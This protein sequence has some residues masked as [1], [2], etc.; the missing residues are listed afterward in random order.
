MA[1]RAPCGHGVVTRSSASARV[2]P[3]CCLGVRATC[4]ARIPSRA[5]SFSHAGWTSATMRADG[6][7]RRR[8]LE[9]CVAICG[10]PRWSLAGLSTSAHS[11]SRGECAQALSRGA[12]RA[13][14]AAAAR[15]AACRAR[16]SRLWA[17]RFALRST[18]GIAAA[19]RL[20]AAACEAATWC[21]CTC[22]CAWRLTPARQ[23]ESC[24]VACVA[25]SSSRAT[26]TDA[27]PGHVVAAA[28]AQESGTLDSAPGA[29]GRAH[30][31]ARA[32]S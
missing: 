32:P 30:P 14:A 25:S 12:S 23:R 18:A 4:A 7:A 3:M 21:C 9:F 20:A 22:G 8:L 27:A 29:L 1:R 11:P 5:P 2:G 16:T 28:P 6:A 31:P 13:A 26:A 10:R 15:S 19:V 24:V 17:A